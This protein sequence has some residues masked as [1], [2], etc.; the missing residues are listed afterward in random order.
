MRDQKECSAVNFVGAPDIP[1]FQR[2]R[3][4]Y[5]QY[6]EHHISTILYYTILQYTIKFHCSAPAWLGAESWGSACPYTK[7]PFAVPKIKLWG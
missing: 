3:A 7:A 5:A 4:W 6:Y 2:G 1:T